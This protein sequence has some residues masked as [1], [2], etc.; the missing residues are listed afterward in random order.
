LFRA[1]LLVLRLLGNALGTSAPLGTRQV[2]SSRRDITHRV[3]VAG[4]VEAKRAAMAAHA[5]QRRAE[6]RR[7]VLDRMLRLPGPVFGM[8]FGHEWFVERG[9]HPIDRST[10]IFA[11]LRARSLA[12]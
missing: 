2:F 7:R 12:R 1:V 11:T 4:Q 10:D 6:G 8:A 5:S 9:R 3:R